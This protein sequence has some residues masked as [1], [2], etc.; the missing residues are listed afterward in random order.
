MIVITPLVQ[1]FIL[2][3]SIF[4][5]FTNVNAQVSFS[6]VGTDFW[7]GF[8]NNHANNST[9]PNVKLLISGATATTG[10]VSIPL[11]GW[12][13]T[14]SII[15]N[16]TTTVIIP[17]ELAVHFSNDVVD[18]RG[19]HVESIDPV[20]LFAEHN[21]LWSTDGTNIFPVS[22]LG[23]DYIVNAYSGVNND[24]GSEF[25]IV[26]TAD[27]T[28]I[29][30]TP[31]VNTEGGHAAGVPYIIDLNEGETYQ[32]NV[33]GAFLD[34]TGTRVKATDQS[35]DCRPFNVFGGSQCSYVPD[36]C[37]SCDHLFEQLSPIFLWGT[38]YYLVPYSNTT[39][40]TYKIIARDNGTLVTV[41]NGVPLAMTAGQVIEVNSVDSAYE[42]LANK[43]ISV[44]QYIHGVGCGGGDPSM[45]SLNA[46]KQRLN[47]VTFST[48]GS[49]YIAQ[50]FLNLIVEASDV[51]TVLLDNVAIPTANYTIF[52]ANPTKSYAQITITEGDHSVFAPN[53]FTAYAYGLGVDESYTFSLGFFETV[54]E[55]LDT[56]ICSS[57]TIILIPQEPFLSPIWTTLSD[58]TTVIGTGDSLLLIPPILNEVYIVTETSML[59]GCLQKYSFS[60]VVPDS[61]IFTMNTD[62]DTVCS[63]SAVQFGVSLTNSGSYG[64]SWTPTA[65]F[66]DP[67]SASPT[68]TIEQNEWVYVTVV[69]PLGCTHK[70][71]MLVHV[72]EIPEVT[73][74]AD[75][76][77]C[78]GSTYLIQSTS[79]VSSPNYLWNTADTVADLIT[80]SEGLFWLEVST[81]CGSDRDSMT[82]AYY[83]SF[84]VDLGNDTTLCFG[85]SLLLAPAIPIGG[86]ATWFNGSNNNTFTVHSPSAI[87]VSIQDV[88]GCEVN[89]SIRIAYF[90]ALTFDLGPDYTICDED[91]IS[92]SYLGNEFDS[93]VWNDG[94]KT[95]LYTYTNTLSVN[96]TITLSAIAY[97]CGSVGDTI[98]IYVEAC[99]CPVFVP[100]TFT[101]DGEQDNNVFKI[102]HECI[103]EE[104]TFIIFNRWGEVLFETQS[105]NFEWDGTFKSR[106][107]VETETYVWRMKYLLT[108]D[109]EKNPAYQVKVGHV[110]VLR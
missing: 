7:L 30:I 78:I 81:S 65:L 22:S 28:Q 46:D 59:S 16:T 88:N 18:T 77:I 108:N 20:S 97:G 98:H 44:T 87:F 106:K 74:P 93:I 69:N 62:L 63:F 90:E 34:L 84:T 57:D 37:S 32:V 10:T 8:M 73:L 56:L 85:D 61:T 11:Q 105:P 39:S 82:I 79:N 12:S 19:I 4:F 5:L 95:N 9:N 42:I 48:M 70:D 91:V 3:C 25:L 110:N 103:F 80:S 67:A 2:V 41:D 15:P 6:T 52:A 92:L 75:T 104:F 27:G 49:F 33:V 101:P 68:L 50:H 76:T 58:P 99:S 54:P 94:R 17:K 47:S 31:S 102:Y 89:D 55:L 64:Y 26:S 100:N 96:D 23:R 71:S 43:P 21:S 109:S 36:W 53:G 72:S 60:V 51:G 14:F 24:E 86:G 13:T 29:E 45:L 66:D 38:E 40:Y 35:G 107:R 83:N 1:R